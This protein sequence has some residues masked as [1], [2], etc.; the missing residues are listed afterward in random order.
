MEFDNAAEPTDCEEDAIGIKADAPTAREPDVG[1]GPAGCEDVVAG[2]RADRLAAGEF[3]IEPE[4]A[5]CND[6]AND[7]AT[8]TP[9]ARVSGIETGPAT[10]EEDAITVELNIAVGGSG[11]ET[12]MAA[13]DE[14]AASTELAATAV[15]DCTVVITCTSLPIP[16]VDTS[17]PS[18]AVVA[19]TAKPPGCPIKM[20][21]STL[22][23]AV[24]SSS[25]SPQS[26]SV[27][28]EETMDILQ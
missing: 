18:G 27:F 20:Y 19:V 5:V 9:V 16:T 2:T 24:S 13:C 25:K 28:R 3:D 8:G 26:A 22:M 1:A 21:P 11:I 17:I 4:R 14:N 7:T 10:C 15:N 23:N 12:E 6:D